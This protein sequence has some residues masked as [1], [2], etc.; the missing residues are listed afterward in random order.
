MDEI[1]KFKNSR[2]TFLL[3]SIKELGYS[4]AVNE[5]IKKYPSD[6]Y[7]FD[8]LEG[9]LAFRCINKNN[10]NCL[11][12]NSDLGNIPDFFSDIFE[13]V[14]SLDTPE[15]ILIQKARFETKKITNVV[16][17]TTNSDEMHS[18]EKNYD[19]II[20]N[21]IQI[22]NL[23]DLKI[24][25]K[26][27]LNKLKNQLNDDGCL[28]LAV[29]NKSGITIID[30]V[31]SENSYFDNFNGYDSLLDSLGLKTESY[32]V[33]PSHEQPHFS[34]K[35]TD[36]I[37]LKWFFDN[38]AKKFSVDQ[39]FKIAGKLLKLLNK[40]TRKSIVLKF[41]PSFL[42]YS[43]K[44]ESIDTLE[45][46]IQKNTQYDSLIQNTRLSKVLFFLLNNHGDP[47]KVLTCKN[48]KYDLTE[49]IISIERKFPEMK[50]PDEKLVLEEWLQGNFL[51]RLNLS[52][53]KLVMKWLIHFQNSTKND[54]L[55]FDEIEKEVENIENELK[56]IDVMANLPYKSWLNDYKEEIR[57]TK[58]K[59]T[60]VHGDFQVRN[61]LIDENS[62]QVNVI[63]WDWEFQEKGNP[64]YD[65]VWLATNIMM[66]SNNPEKEFLKNQNNHGRAMK[67]IDIIKKTMNEHL[68]S[69]FDFLKLQK[70]MILR[71]I[72]SRVKVGDG[73]HLLYVNILKLLS[74][75][76][77][78]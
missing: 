55:T 15:K 53:V 75:S 2:L 1:T 49:K 41:C 72:T 52:H 30:G 67:S 20:L 74:N 59:K 10:K 14:V 51:D 38:F 56:K 21:G 43:Y 27:Y 48:T 29:K 35:L 44:N 24:R 22:E 63:D 66:L 4:K 40:N 39:K 12:I 45:K 65:F 18:I 57:K 70:F 31:T 34:G 61:I 62:D 36:D 37:S 25:I 26:N 47:K 9:S 42:F 58:L 13:E 17:E 69:N 76:N 3:E 32:W 5:F 6:K 46:M 7:R 16:F 68:K 28:C 54:D 71:F 33:L 19:L 8:K 60:G 50:N 78:Y 11:I 73:G 77:S 23:H 64:I